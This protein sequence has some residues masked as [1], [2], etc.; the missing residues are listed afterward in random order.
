[1]GEVMIVWVFVSY[2]TIGNKPLQVSGD[3]KYAFVK[4]ETCKKMIEGLDKMKC[5][6]L[7]LKE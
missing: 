2:I 6:P 4:E 3:L 7:E 5:I 1:M